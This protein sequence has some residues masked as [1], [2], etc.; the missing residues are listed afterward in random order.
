VA[1]AQQLLD[2]TFGR[3]KLSPE[4]EAL[5]SPKT[6]D[7]ARAILVRD[8]AF[9][10][11]RAIDVVHPMP[12]TEA[13]V[14]EAQLELLLGETQLLGSRILA[15]QVLVAGF[16]VETA[17]ARLATL[18]QGASTDEARELPELVR[19]IDEGAELGRALSMVAPPHFSAAAVLVRDLE[20]AAPADPRV[21]VLR[22]ELH[23]F[24]GEWD[25]FDADVAELERREPASPGL[26]YVRALAAWSRKGDRDAAAALFRDLRTRA[27]SFLRAQAALV[28]L[29]KTPDEALREVQALRAASPSHYLVVLLEPT[30]AA[31]QELS[32][33][34]GEGWR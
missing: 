26:L 21:L 9:L 22:A 15:E 28:L 13:R 34:R 1:D 31:E 6:L 2:S 29:A 7:D 33:R 24:R 32:R 8:Q 12:G 20:K 3:I 19:A 17:R 16:A 4:D 25:A 18:P 23:R 5:A 10:F 30:L 11:R 27:P 14:T